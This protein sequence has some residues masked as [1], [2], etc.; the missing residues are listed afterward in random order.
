MSYTPD[1]QLLE[2]PAIKAAKALEELSA[3]IKERLKN[4]DEWSEK[5]LEEL[6]VLFRDISDMEI[7]LRQLAARNR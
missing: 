5:H 6:L 4:Q 1:N 7:R 2:K 3:P